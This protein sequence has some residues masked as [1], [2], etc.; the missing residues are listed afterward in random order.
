MYDTFF[1]SI[2][3]CKHIGANYFSL[4]SKTAEDLKKRNSLCVGSLTA[5]I[6]DSLLKSAAPKSNEL[7]AKKERF[8]IFVAIKIQTKEMQLPGKNFLARRAS[9]LFWKFALKYENKGSV[10]LNNEHLGGERWISD[11]IFL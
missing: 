11:K 5:V 8:P 1:L 9:A 2:R 10:K 6:G 3:L 7:L 4:A